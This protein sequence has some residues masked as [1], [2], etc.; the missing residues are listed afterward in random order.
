MG[1]PFVYRTEAKVSTIEAEDSTHAFYKDWGR[2]PI[3]ISHGWP[4][5]A[6]VWNDQ[7]MLFESSSRSHFLANSFRLCHAVE[8]Q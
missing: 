2:Q 1:L 4:L 7:L 5:N 8:N 6:D 3:V